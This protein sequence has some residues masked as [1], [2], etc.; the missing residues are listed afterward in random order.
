MSHIHQAVLDPTGQYLVFPDLGADL[1]RVYCID[2]GSG[3][4]TEHTSLKSKHG[5]GPRH[6]TFWSSGDAKSIYMFVIHELSNKII[7]YE[8]GYLESGGLTFSEIDEVSTY[9]D[10]DIP[11]GAKAAEVLIYNNFL[12]VSN[13]NGSIFNAP[14]PDLN[15]STTIPSDSLATFK[16]SLAGSLSFVQLAPTGG[17]FP[18]HWY[19][20]PSTNTI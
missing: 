18:R 19:D 7:S 1:V 12:V 14:N 8:V 3:L 4:L 16:L 6:A 5:Y 13:R 17:T 15:N 10:R 9:G 2:Q 20:N 11:V